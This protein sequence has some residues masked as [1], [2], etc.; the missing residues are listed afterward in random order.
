MSV[1]CDNNDI[2]HLL[3]ID[4]PASLTH[5]FQEIGRVGRNFYTT[6]KENIVDVIVEAKCFMALLGRA[7]FRCNE[8]KLSE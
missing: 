4:L 1:G 3:R 5:A 2:K 6:S 7:I 8:S